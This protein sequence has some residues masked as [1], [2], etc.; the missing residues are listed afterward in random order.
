MIHNRKLIG[1]GVEAQ[2]CFVKL[3]TVTK[4]K[5]HCA[6]YLSM[7]SQR[8]ET[9]RSMLDEMINY[10]HSRHSGACLIP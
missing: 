8:K 3:D 7:S 10:C 6:T 1:K 4:K 5:P 9:C 2:L